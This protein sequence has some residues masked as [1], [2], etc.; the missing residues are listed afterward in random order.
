MYIYCG[1]PTGPHNICTHLLNVPTVWFVNW[2]DDG[3]MSRNMLPVLLI[4]NKLS[5]VFRLNITIFNLRFVWDN[6]TGWSQ[7]KH[8]DAGNK[9][10]CGPGSIFQQLK[11]LHPIMCAISGRFSYRIFQCGLVIVVQLRDPQGLLIL[12][13]L[14]FFHVVYN[15]RQ[16]VQREAWSN[17]E[18][19]EKIK[20]NLTM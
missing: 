2:P 10:H 16:T 9:Q 1:I 7:S 6:T 14:W 8:T 13:N 19:E 12:H 5:V 3:P 17:F 11:E 20:W 4:N 15:K 18:N